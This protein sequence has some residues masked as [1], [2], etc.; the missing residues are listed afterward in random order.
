M[1]I[2]G[3]LIVLLL[4][5]CMILPVLAACKSS[6]DVPSNEN[7]ENTATG[8]N[9]KIS[10]EGDSQTQKAPL[11]LPDVKYNGYDFK[12]MNVAQS[13]MTW[14]YTTITAEEETG[15]GIN[16]AV[17]IRNSL[18]EDRFGIKITEIIE[19]SQDSILSKAS[20]SIQSGGNDYDMILLEAN[21]AIGMAKKNFLVDYNE[22]PYIDLTKSYWD[23]DM[24]RDFSI[25]K[26][27]YFIAGDFSMMHYGLTIAMFFN[28]KLINDLNLESPYD[29][30]NEGKWTY[31]KFSEMARVASKDLNGDGKYDKNDQYG[32]LSITHIWAPS[33]LASGGE[34]LIGKDA[35]NLHTFAAGNERFIS[36]FQKMIEV[37]HEGNMLFDADTAGDHRLQDVMFPG[38][39][40]LF[41][42]EVVHWATILRDMNADF[43]IIVHPKFDENQTSYYNFTGQSPV[44]CIPSTAQDLERT[45]MIYEALCYES[46]DTVITA[47]YDVLLKTKISRDNESE[48]MLNIM[49]QNRS[50][51]LADAFYSAEAHTPWWNLCKKKD[52]DISSWIAKNEAKINAAIQK[53]NTALAED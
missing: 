43:G 18:V 5:A 42:S 53:A 20:K 13:A 19:N 41:W 50:Y 31:D 17:Y 29:I 7:T 40:A 14:I 37:M 48:E 25:G 27:N 39:Q 30:I 4:I 47:Y 44:M 38:N 28:K 33:F 35:N 36:V 34:Q 10:D 8:E 3:K 24:V 45:G 32:Y 22:M 6:T 15:D 21:K 26:H 1:K 23:K 12:I 2:T 46:K 52:A 16:D 11:D 49:F 51:N 9:G